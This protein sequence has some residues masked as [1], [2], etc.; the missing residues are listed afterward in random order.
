MSNGDLIGA[1]VSYGNTATTPQAVALQT[2]L[3]G[4]SGLSGWFQTGVP[5]GEAYYPYCVVSEL[6]FEKLKE[7]AKQSFRIDFLTVQFEAYA[8]SMA[9]VDQ[10]LSAIEACYIN[11]P[12]G[13][14]IVDRYTVM[15]KP[16]LLDRLKFR[17]LDNY[18]GILNLG[19]GLSKSPQ[20]N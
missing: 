20:G 18:R 7:G 13:S 1:L 15:D 5:K 3:A 10:I 8:L 11:A 16:Y 6:H 9:T 19:F 17:E 14:L 12:V 4:G 2:L